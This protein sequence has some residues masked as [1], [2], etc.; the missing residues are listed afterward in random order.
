[1]M[2]KFVA[3]LDKEMTEFKTQVSIFRRDLE[4]EWQ[5]AAST[6]DT[7]G[8][9]KYVQE[10]KSRTKAFE[11]TFD[12]LNEGHSIVGDRERFQFT[13]Q[14]LAAKRQWQAL[15]IEVENKLVYLTRQEIDQEKAVDSRTSD[16]LSDWEKTKPIEGN[17]KPD[18]AL[19][20]L[21]VFESKYSR[22]KEER[23]QVGKAKK[24]LQLLESSP[25]STNEESLQVTY[26]SVNI[27][28]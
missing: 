14:W 20:C 1:M 26:F 8:F 2:C 3:Q 12:V 24:A 23:E 13:D 18:E 11:K 4:I 10:L 17:A 19:Q 5:E 6:D 15:L 7:V 27:Y 25:V 16:Y 21:Q 28:C 22:L 9:I